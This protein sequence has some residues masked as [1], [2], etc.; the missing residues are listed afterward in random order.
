M[1]QGHIRLLREFANWRWFRDPSVCHL[2]VYLLL[3]ANFE[4]N[5]YKDRIIKRGQL[6]TGIYKLSAETGLSSSQVRTAL[7]K[8]SITHEITT[9]STRS[10][11][12]ITICKYDSYLEASQ[13][14]SKPIANQSQT[15]S[16]Q[17]ANQ[18]QQS[19]NDNNIKN[20][21]NDKN[22]NKEDANASKKEISY[23][24]CKT[25][26]QKEAFE[27][28]FLVAHNV[29]DGTPLWNAMCDWFAYR[30]EINK[31][32]KSERSLE[33]CLREIRKLSNGKTETAIEIINQSI[34]NG[35]QGLFAIKDEPPNKKLSDRQRGEI[36]TH[37]TTEN[38]EEI[39]KVTSETFFD[40]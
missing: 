25:K 28:K 18:S 35:W 31:P 32:Y 24:A 14:D 38:R 10:C 21:N 17:I 37:L 33:G 27:K 8:L 19:N 26:G 13:T 20:D 23:S 9:S 3:Q 34:A 15:D 16:K 4:D 12:L 5:E 39:R 22:E 1:L 40:I 29:K 2:F 7:H 30:R 6:V 36:A 11:T